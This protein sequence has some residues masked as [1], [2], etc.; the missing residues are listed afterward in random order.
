MCKRLLTVFAV[1]W[2]T[3]SLSAGPRSTAEAEQL[4]AYFFEKHAVKARGAVQLGSVALAA[5]SADLSTASRTVRQASSPAYYVYNQADN[6]F[7]IISGDD[8]MPDVLG[9]SFEGEFALSEVP[10]NMRAWLQLY[11]LK[12]DELDAPGAV[13]EPSSAPTADEGLAPSVEPLLG[14]INYNQNDPYNRKCP[15]VDGQRSVTGC[16]A[17]AMAQVMRY[18]KYPEKGMRV[19]GYTTSSNQIQLTYNYMQTTFDWDNML[20]TYKSGEYDAT[21][22]DA[23]AELMLACGVAASMDYDPSSSGAFLWTGMDGMIE[24]LKYNPYAYITS[25]G[26]YSLEGWTTL[27]KTEMNAQ[28]PVICTAYDDTGAGHAFVLDGYDEEGRFH[29]NWGW[30]GS[31]NGYYLVT[32]LEPGVV[33]IGG[34]SGGGYQFDQLVA[35]GLAPESDAFEMQSHFE[36][37]AMSIDTVRN[38]AN[39]KRLANY[40]SEFS[41]RVALIAEADGVQRVISNNQLLNNV[42]ING[43]YSSLNFNLTVTSLVPDGTYDV[44]LGSRSNAARKW[45]KVLCRYGLTPEYKLVVENGKFRIVVDDDIALMPEITLIPHSEELHSN[46][47]ELV[48][49]KIVNPRQH[50]DFNGWMEV[51]LLDSNQNFLSSQRIEQVYVGPG[52]TDSVECAVKI[53]EYVG[54]A[55]LRPNWYYSYTSHYLG[56]PLEVTISEQGTPASAVRAIRCKL[57]SARVETGSDIVCTGQ[58]GISGTGD[59]FD[60]QMEARLYR[61][62]S[63]SAALKTPRIPVNLEKGK[64][65]DFSVELNADVTP[66]SYTFHLYTYDPRTSSYTDQ[67]SSSVFVTVVVGISSVEAE[68]QLQAAV[69]KGASTVRLT[70]DQP[71]R[72]VRLYGTQGALLRQT[73]LQSDERAY[74]LDV[75]GLPAGTY[76]VQVTLADGTTQQVK[77]VR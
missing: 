15:A 1:A 7:V 64:V 11:E 25:S 72:S 40:S 35:I 45:N 36:A 57:S 66:G 50:H 49:M 23:V 48:T 77:F 67:W 73:A 33:G 58:L 54:K 63:S 10:D 52:E 17:T 56:E 29:L 59:Y 68:S 12:R 47:T 20:P 70:S 46:R 65:Q 62:G 16:T 4:A 51:A 38:T 24:Y 22:A 75:A 5:T 37:E 32:R 53:P 6:G 27:L 19:K 18:Y 31:S 74:N 30:G 3:L 26:C 71:M 13:V 39:V 55:Y 28:R 41:G 8:R 43:T 34:G 21:E 69:D 9:Y 76:I 60:G 14:D 2:G 44:Y 61:N 42:G